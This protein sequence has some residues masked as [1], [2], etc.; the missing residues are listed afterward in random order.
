M[1][2][3][4]DRLFEKSIKLLAFISLLLLSFIIL[5]IFKESLIFF[6]AVPILKFITRNTWNPLAAPENLSI[7]NIILGTLYV[8]IVAIIIALP[9]G[10]GSSLLLSGYVK[11]KPRLIL[12]GLIDV[13]A[14]VPSVIYGFIG[15]L[16]L[17]KFFER[18]FDFSSGESVL[19]GGILLSIMVLPY[20]IST[21]D[22]TMGKMYEKYSIAAKALGIS[23][24]YIIRTI[25]LS[26][27]IKGIT[28]AAVLALGRAMGETMAVMMVIGNAPIM[29]KLLG[30]CQTIPS[31]IALE[32]GMAEVGS[33][34]YH[35]LFAAGFVLMAILLI[36]N[37]ALFYIKRS[38]SQL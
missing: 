3:V 34:H 22:E 11:E 31:L 18:V 25:V 37:I 14:G 24:G 33:L 35:A 20:I 21:C 26:Q 32:M 9:I 27:S 30:K 28:A 16:V 19:A 8:S 6:R 10:V 2:E 13:M 38:M 1:W 29:P 15:L 7:L 23:K 17:V 5:F 36:I 12:R 4:L